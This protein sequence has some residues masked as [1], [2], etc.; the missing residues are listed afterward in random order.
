M[1]KYP[2]RIM[3][4]AAN[5]NYAEML[6]LMLLALNQHTESPEYELTDIRPPGIP[7]DECFEPTVSC[8]KEKDYEFTV[9]LDIIEIIAVT[10]TIN[11][12]KQWREYPVCHSPETAIGS[13]L[14]YQLF[15]RYSFDLLPQPRTFAYIFYREQR[16]H[17]EQRPAPGFSKLNQ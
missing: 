6:M 4:P 1:N 7:A 13:L 16:L 2:L 3:V 15:S 5:R 14:L 11:G 17:D 12:L 10:V 9:Q 8:L